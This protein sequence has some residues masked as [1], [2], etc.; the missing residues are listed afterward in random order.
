[1]VKILVCLLL[2]A[3]L[4]ALVLSD[5]GLDLGDCACLCGLDRSEAAAGDASEVS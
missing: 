4:P 5:E 3:L 1:M 2:V